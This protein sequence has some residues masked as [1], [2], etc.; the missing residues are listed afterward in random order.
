MHDDLTVVE[1]RPRTILRSFDMEGFHAALVSQVLLDG[2]DDRVHLTAVR[3]R[4]DH[5]E[6][7]LA[8]KLRHILDENVGRL[9]LVGCLSSDDCEFSR[10]FLFVSAHLRSFRFVFMYG[11]SFFTA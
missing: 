9:L 1:Q 7:G 5:E 6:V 10:G 8:D 3:R 2:V 11:F 4:D